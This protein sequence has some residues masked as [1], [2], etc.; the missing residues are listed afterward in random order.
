MKSR[1][2]AIAAI[3][4]LSIGLNAQVNLGVISG[5]I[6]DVD[7]TTTMPFARVWVET[8]SGL[9]GSNADI[10]GRFKID[11]LRPGTYNLHA[12]T[13]EKGE[14]VVSAVKVDPDGI[15]T[16]NV[17]MTNNNMLTVV[18]IDFDIDSWKNLTKGKTVCK[19]FP[20]ELK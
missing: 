3:L 6:Y 9:V 14:M 10:D 1:L 7:S 19:I 12:K 8:E 2:L 13:V 15:T 16:V 18:V 11:A 20:K 4:F 17:Y 5:V